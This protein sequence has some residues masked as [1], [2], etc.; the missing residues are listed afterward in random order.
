MITSGRVI[1]FQNADNIILIEGFAN[2]NIKTKCIDNNRVIRKISPHD[3]PSKWVI[4]ANIDELVSKHRQL[5]QN[6][7][8]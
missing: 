4:D 8:L 7:F 1:I 2:T 5:R 6:N 3:R